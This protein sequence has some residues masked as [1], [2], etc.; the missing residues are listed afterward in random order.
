MA[1][2]LSRFDSMRFLFKGLFEISGLCRPRTIAHLKNN[3]REAID[4]IPI[5]MLQRVDTNFENR[6][7][8]CIRN[9][10]RDLPDVIFKTV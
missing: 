3:I 9:G 7:H 1:A 4:N 6:L 8:Q 10:G 2:T 5:D